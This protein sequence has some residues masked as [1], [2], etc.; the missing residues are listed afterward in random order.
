MLRRA[1]VV[2]GLCASFQTLGCEQSVQA[3]LESNLALAA[4]RGGQV[5]PTWNKLRRPPKSRGLGPSRRVQAVSVTTSDAADAFRS[6]D[7]CR[8]LLRQGARVSRSSGTARI[9]SWNVRW[10]P[11][12]VAG[13]V[14][15]SSLATDIE[16]M[17]C[18]LAW[19]NVDAVALAEV[20][21][22]PRSLPALEQLVARLDA[23][24][25]GKHSIRIDD[26]PDESGQH[27]AWLLNEQ[28][29]NATDWQMH[30]PIN[31]NGEA[32]SGQL[33]PGLGVRLRFI[34]G[35]DLHAIAVHFKS[36]VLPR[37][38]ALRRASFDGL[39]RVLGSVTSRTG[40]ADVL[41]A[42]DFNTMG[43]KTC[44][45][46]TR[47][48]AESSWLDNRL[49]AFRPSARRVPSDLGCSLYYQGQPSLLDHFL[50]TSAMREAPSD[51]L[52]SVYGHCRSFACDVPSDAEPAAST[53]LSDHCPIVL[54]L[55]DQDLD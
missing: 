40:D 24:T 25:A 21:S 18:A 3:N 37:D 32:C 47:S 15:D 33:R 9:A 7:D 12:G 14:A 49:R 55:L 30:A 19:M 17:A 28:R 1:G 51:N 11:D 42:G 4:H 38:L 20:K 2:I 44:T 10:F 36:G 23:L 27:V 5:T 48:A 46:V 50:V 8:T 31:P 52:A 35:L 39:E 26:C 53:R 45:A 6:A 29:V 13:E 41:V 22:K 43:C 34:G 16:W 54:T